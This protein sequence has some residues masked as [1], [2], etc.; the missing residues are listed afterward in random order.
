[1]NADATPNATHIPRRCS[2]MW[3]AWP[4]AIGSGWWRANSTSD[5]ASDSSTSIQVQAGRKVMAAIAM[6]TR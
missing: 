5:D 4:P 6:G 3:P 2:A 1:M